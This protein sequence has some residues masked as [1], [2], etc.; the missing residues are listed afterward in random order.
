MSWGGIDLIPRGGGESSQDAVDR[1]YAGGLLITFGDGAPV[2][3]QSPPAPDTAGG[4][5]PVSA[6]WVPEAIELLEA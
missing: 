2:V 4:P 5:D 6:D 3:E 1:V